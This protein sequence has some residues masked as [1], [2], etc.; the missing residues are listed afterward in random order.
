METAA[1]IITDRGSEEK[2]FAETL[3]AILGSDSVTGADE[4]GVARGLQLQVKEKNCLE[5][6]AKESIQAET[7]G[8]E[9][10]KKHGSAKSKNNE[11]NAKVSTPPT[12]VY[13]PPK[14]Q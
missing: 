4:S 13:L 10:R 1:Y 6:V 7:L 11:T 3:R 12:P 14:K 2:D 5:N 9:L 8:K